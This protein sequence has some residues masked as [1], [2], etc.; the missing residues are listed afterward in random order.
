MVAAQPKTI[1]FFHGQLKAMHLLSPSAGLFCSRQFEILNVHDHITRRW[2]AEA[3][4][5]SAACTQD[6][7]VVFYLDPFCS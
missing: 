5:S 1:F 4:D 2:I 3:S 6:P 7:P